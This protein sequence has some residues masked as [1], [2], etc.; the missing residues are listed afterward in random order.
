MQIVFSYY[1][2]SANSILVPLIIMSLLQIVMSFLLIVVSLLQIV[3]SLLLIV[4]SLLL[5][6]THNS[7]TCN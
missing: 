1:F 6:N 7:Y 2:C 3:M 4:M 5:I